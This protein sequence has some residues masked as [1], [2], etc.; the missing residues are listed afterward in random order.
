MTGP[1][2]KW[3]G[4]AV[5]LGL[6]ACGVPPSGVIQAGAPATGMSPATTLYFVA[7]GEDAT[8]VAVPRRTAAPVDPATAVALLLGGPE[9]YEQ[10]KLGTE[11]PRFS[12]PPSVFT[13]S[14][15][16]L[17]TL[18]KDAPRL[19]AIAVLQ[20][21]CTAGAA[22]TA[23]PDTASGKAAD[24]APTRLG[25]VPR[26]TFP[27]ETVPG[28]AVPTAVPTAPGAPRIADPGAVTVSVVGEGW[29]VTRSADSC[30]AA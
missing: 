19:G 28:K 15:G 7:R 18:P 3:L 11:L 21:V 14:G 13:T 30:P 6:T 12:A 27:S 5:L 4:L 22:F 8:L 2:L 29:R 1:L 10:P 23:G 17:V 9:E 26:R 24:S 25:A 16:V 20:L